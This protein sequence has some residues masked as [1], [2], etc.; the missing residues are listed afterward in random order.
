ML[1]CL[2]AARLA[3]RRIAGLH[4]RS[5]EP[6]AQL[7]R[8]HLGEAVACERFVGFERVAEQS[9]RLAERELR[10]GMRRGGGR[11]VQQR[12]ASRR[13]GLDVMMHE[14]GRGRWRGGGR[15]QLGEPEVQPLALFGGER[16]M[17][18]LAHQ[19]VA[20]AI[21]AGRDLEQH[22]CVD[23]IGERHRELRAR[24]AREPRQGRAAELAPDDRGELEHRARGRRERSE[25]LA[26]HRRARCSESRTRAPSRLELPRA[27]RL[28]ADRP[29]P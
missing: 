25:A 11:R 4:E 20:E 3:E 8:L 22:R 17:Q 10:L 12:R 9:R 19:D 27:R 2:A 26:D 28:R 7:D 5:A 14:L 23:C 18:H 16:L 6:N 15:E 24:L 13:A 1:G 21:L 29:A